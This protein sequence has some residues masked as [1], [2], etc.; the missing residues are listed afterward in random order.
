MSIAKLKE[1]A[2]DRFRQRFI[3][4]EVLDL[5][6]PCNG[7]EI[8][9]YIDALIDKVVREVEWGTEIEEED[10]APDASQFAAGWNRARQATKEAFRNFRDV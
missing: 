8:E 9:C 5:L 3:G 10:G 1:D 2:R 7:I 6:K 4:N